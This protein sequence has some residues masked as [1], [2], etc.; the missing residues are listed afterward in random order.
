[1]YQA[2][3]G[4]HSP[5][6]VVWHM[7][8]HLADQVEQRVVAPLLRAASVGPLPRVPAGFLAAYL[9]CAPVAPVAAI[10][11]WLDH[12]CQE[13]PEMMAVL[14]QHAYRPELLRMLGVDTDPSA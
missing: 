14:V 1:L 12:D 9:G 13:S 3:L 7:H 8:V 10:T 2:Q 4:E 5:D 11:R 6:L